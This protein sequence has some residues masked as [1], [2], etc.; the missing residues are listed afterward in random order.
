MRK[1]RATPRRM[2]DPP[3]CR[4]PGRA[5]ECHRPAPAG[6]STRAARDGDARDHAIRGLERNARTLYLSPRGRRCSTVRSAAAGR[7]CWTTV[8]VGSTPAR[9][10]ALRALPDGS[11][12]VSR[13]N[14]VT[15]VGQ[16]EQNVVRNA[17]TSLHAGRSRRHSGD[18][19]TARLRTLGE[20]PLD[21]AR[22]YVPF[23]RI[24]LDDRGVAAAE[25]VRY[26]EP[27]A[28]NPRVLHVLRLHTE[29]VC[30]QMLDPRAAAA[31]AGILVDRND[32]IWLPGGT[33]QSYRR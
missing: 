10:P 11:P 26:A 29:A 8:A 23:D 30:P 28:V 6:R 1:S 31:S 20:E 18:R 16:D 32:C 3:S 22:G 13:V 12:A 7:K 15:A 2:P 4:I 17:P 19:E 9:L 25:R 27:G 24:A 21:L 14:A 5:L 33:G